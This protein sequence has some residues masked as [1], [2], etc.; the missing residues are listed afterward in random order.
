MAFSGPL[1]IKNAYTTKEHINGKERG[2]PTTPEQTGI[3][4]A[5]SR[6]TV[7][8]VVHADKIMATLKADNCKGSQTSDINEMEELHPGL[9]W[10][11]SRSEAEALT[12]LLASLACKNVV[13]DV[14][15]NNPHR[16]GRELDADL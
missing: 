6:T 9:R 11:L 8:R 4:I 10:I 14:R 16:Q 13:K 15:Y 12:I 5:E 7:R 2:T 1:T 3:E